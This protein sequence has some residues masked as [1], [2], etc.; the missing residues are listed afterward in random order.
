[1]VCISLERLMGNLLEKK[2]SVYTVHPLFSGHTIK[3]STCSHRCS[4]AAP[5]IAL[6]ILCL[7]ILWMDSSYFDQG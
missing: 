4:T 1:M 2:G 7:K 3:W 6:V 5:E